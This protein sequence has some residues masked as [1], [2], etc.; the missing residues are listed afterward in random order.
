MNLPEVKIKKILYPTDLSEYARK[1]FAY[2]VS[3]ANQYNASITILHVIIDNTDMYSGIVNY[4]G[5][6]KW[7]QIRNEYVENAREILI[8]KKRE[9]IP[10]QEILALFCKEAQKK[11]GDQGFVMD[12]IVVA[13]GNPALE[14]VK[15]SEERD[16]DV[17]VMGSHG[18]G[19][20]MDTMLG[21]TTQK[22]LRKSKKPVLI[23]KIE[24]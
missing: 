10:V 16:C 21:S 24:D 22:V 3:L 12:E 15:Q 23:V 13:K 6:E 9:N 19:G 5:K 20:L 1:A 11:Y 2:A 18:H 17:I 4:V 8:G 14:I 7:D